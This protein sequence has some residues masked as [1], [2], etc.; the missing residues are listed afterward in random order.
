MNYK[1][2]MEQATALLNY[3]KSVSEEDSV[4]LEQVTLVEADDHSFGYSPL[5]KSIC[6]SSFALTGS[7]D[8]LIIDYINNEFGIGLKNNELTRSVH[9]FLHEL[10]HHVDMSNRTEEEL[11]NYLRE[12]HAYDFHIKLRTSDNMDTIVDITQEMKDIIEQAME[13]DIRIDDFFEI[14]DSLVDRYQETRVERITIDRDYRLNPAERFADE[15]AAKI[16]DNYLRKTMPQL[17][18]EREHIIR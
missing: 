6:I 3:I 4:V 8:S 9:A 16:M 1:F 15:F 10:G 18:E 12:Y 11:N 2:G 5:H 14:M 7:Q 17:F 13:D